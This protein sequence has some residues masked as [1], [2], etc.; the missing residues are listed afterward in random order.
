M[1]NEKI[2][3]IITKLI[4]EIDPSLDIEADTN[5]IEEDIVDSIFIMEL[6]AE[7]EAEFDVEIDGDEIDPD[8]FESV[9]TVI[10][11]MERV[12]S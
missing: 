11:M 5:L 12:L 7:L 1:N 3:N 8:N 9:N 6:I 10:S 2:M 4:A